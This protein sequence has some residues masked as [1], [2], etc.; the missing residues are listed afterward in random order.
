VGLSIFSAKIIEDPENAGINDPQDL[1][2]LGKIYTNLR[3]YQKGI[4]CLEKA[5]LNAPDEGFKLKIGEFLAWQYKRIGEWEK[6]EKIWKALSSDSGGDKLRPYFRKE[7]LVFCPYEE[8][9]KYYEHKVKDYSLALEMVDKAL[10][11]IASSLGLE[12]DKR[13]RE[14]ERRFCHRK[15]RLK[16][17]LLKNI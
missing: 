8:L 6:A 15:E 4:L 10:K 16:R 14:I 11:L 9:A 1:F 17:K 12:E 13:F 5:W 7:P 2:S 3:E